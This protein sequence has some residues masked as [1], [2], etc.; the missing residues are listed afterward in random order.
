MR[1]LLTLLLSTVLL[2]AVSGGTALSHS[3]VESATPGP[4]DKVPAGVEQ[5]R[6]VFD[7]LSPSGE[8]RVRVLDSADS[9]WATG[10][11]E[12][13][14]STVTVPTDALDAGVYQVSYT[15]V[16]G[17]GHKSSS[18]YYFE[19]TPNPNHDSSDGTMTF[20]IIVSAAAGVG[21]LGAIAFMLL[22]RRRE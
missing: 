18:A 10:D 4:G 3:G 17:D 20:V 21:L 2:T 14:D 12:V 6:L 9:D 15:V 13:V 22:R 8:H 11:P 5:V 16:S 19:A 1:R 7:S